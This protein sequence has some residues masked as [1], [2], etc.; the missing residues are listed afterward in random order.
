MTLL[1]FK[2]PA[3]CVT[4]MTS[5]LLENSQTTSGSGTNAAKLG[6]WG[7]SSRS[8]GLPP[9]QA[10]ALLQRLPRHPSPPLGYLPIQWPHVC[11]P[12]SALLSNPQMWP[13]LVTQT[14]KNL[15]AMQKTRVG[16]LGQEEPWVR[17]IHWRRK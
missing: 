12:Q 8:S 4:E 9:G 7:S 15:T 14:V 16:S 1:T 6:G 2:Q 3:S 11:H 10:T 17:K 13:P 5:F